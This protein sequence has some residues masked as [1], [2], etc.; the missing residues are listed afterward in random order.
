MR[1][2]LAAALSESEGDPLYRRVRDGIIRRIANGEWAAGAR[3]PPEPEL[4]RE[5]G[6]SIATLRAAVGELEVAGILSR[7]QGRG[8]FLALQGNSESIH[9]YF[10]VFHDEGRR[11]LPKSEVLSM[12]RGTATLVEAVTLSLGADPSNQAV[13]RVRNL[14]R[15]ADEPVQISDIVMPSGLFPGLTRGM[16]E[17]AGDTLYEAYQRL[18]GIIVVGV[19]DRVKASIADGETARVLGVPR[20]AA[21]LAVERVAITF[22]DQPVEWR[23]T[24]IRSDHYHL[25]LK[26]GGIG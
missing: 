6:V 18:Y 24:R 14:L 13:L 11:P 22:E 21:V 12:R 1:K 20:G 8:T 2:P 19:R 17:A 16:L 9:R 15:V 10:R 23:Q 26:Q 5:F 7:Q 25:L 4:A 3:L